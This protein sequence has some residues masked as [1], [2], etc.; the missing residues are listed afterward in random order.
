M[1]FHDVT[2][3]NYKV[4]IEEIN[5]FIRFLY[6]FLSKKQPQQNLTYHLCARVM[7]DF[8]GF[9]KYGRAVWL[10]MLPGLLVQFLEDFR[11]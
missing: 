6:L 5:K 10:L 11:V 1:I 3:F 8:M 9:V 4:A 7:K 2:L